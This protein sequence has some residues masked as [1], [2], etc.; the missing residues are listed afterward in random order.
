MQWIY[1][2]F[3]DNVLSKHVFFQRI[4]CTLLYY[5][6]RWRHNGHGGVSNHQPHHCLLNHLVRRR[7]KKISKLPVTGLCAGNSPGTGEFPAQMASNTENVSSWW[8]HH[9]IMSST[10]WRCDIHT[11]SHYL[12]F[13]WSI[14]PDCP[15][16]SKKNTKLWSLISFLLI[17][18]RFHQTN[19]WVVICDAST[20]MWSN[21]LILL[22]A[23]TTHILTVNP[24]DVEADIFRENLIP[25]VPR[26]SEGTCMVITS[27]HWLQMTRTSWQQI[28]SF[29]SSIKFSTSKG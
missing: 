19:G 5:T 13:M 11:Y 29:V 16:K 4:Y 25:C 12:S 3:T 10:W 26:T 22:P 23:V 2:H 9:D 17:R 24:Y 1:I 28:V 14:R 7:S 15:Y 6:L 18:I 20:L 21:V 27:S 8:R